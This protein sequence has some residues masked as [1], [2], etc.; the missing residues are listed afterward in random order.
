VD[1]TD[2]GLGI[3]TSEP[4]AADSFVSVFGDISNGDSLQEIEARARV[5][6]CLLRPDGSYRAGLSFR[7]L[8]YQ[9]PFFGTQ[10]NKQKDEPV[11][12]AK[13]PESE[14]YRFSTTTK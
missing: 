12:K 1:I 14:P 5:A 2:A 3:K 7:S 9:N 13:E 8:G 10:T 4:V 11:P 6:C